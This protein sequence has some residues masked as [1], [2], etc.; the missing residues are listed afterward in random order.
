MS[1]ISADVSYASGNVAAKLTRSQLERRAGDPTVSITRRTR[2][3]R[4]EG[5]DAAALKSYSDTLG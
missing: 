5:R 4:I 2:A 1:A 3:G